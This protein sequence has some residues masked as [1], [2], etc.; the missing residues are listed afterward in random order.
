MRK[1][2]NGEQLSSPTLRAKRKHEKE[3]KKNLQKLNI[4]KPI[5]RECDFSLRLWAIRLSDSFGARRKVILLG[6]G[7][8]WA[9][10]LRSFDK[11]RKIGIL[12]YLKL[13]FI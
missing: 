3:K 11:L 10:V 4:L 13:H 8:A 12:S 7:N 2:Q 9:P 1:G 6:E 5:E